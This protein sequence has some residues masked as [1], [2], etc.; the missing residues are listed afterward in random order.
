MENTNSVIVKVPFPKVQKHRVAGLMKKAVTIVGKYDP[1]ALHIE[2]T[3]NLA[4]DSLPLLDKLEVVNRKHPKTEV[5]DVIRVRR[6]DLIKAVIKHT[7]ALQDAKI[8]AQLEQLKLI[9]AVKNHFLKDILRMDMKSKSDYL[10]KFFIA[11]DA[12]ATLS[13]AFTALGYA[14]FLTELRGYETNYDVTFDVRN[15]GQSE[16]PKMETAQVKKSTT[17]YL[18]NLVKVIEAA[19]I[20]H[21]DLDYKPLMNELNTLF[22]S[23]NTEIKVATTINKAKLAKAKT[24]TAT[25][26]TLTSDTVAE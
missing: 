3:Y 7:K 18:R 15:Q 22:V 20:E 24:K 1:A 26:T 11:I 9:V 13:T 8:P 4:V 10:G 17:F 14:V 23:Y 21:S 2:N 25:A 19:S 5:L 12:D 6:D 16:I